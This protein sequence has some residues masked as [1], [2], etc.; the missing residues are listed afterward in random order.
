MPALFLPGH[1]SLL[2]AAGTHLTTKLPSTLGLAF[3][4]GL[5]RVF[6][7]LVRRRPPCPAL[8]WPLLGL[9]R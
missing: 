5:A 4:H 6:R 7:M 9:W 8:P 1:W 3:T 2:G